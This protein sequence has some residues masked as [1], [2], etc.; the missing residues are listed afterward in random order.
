[1]DSEHQYLCWHR[2]VETSTRGFG[3]ER[4]KTRASLTASLQ[5]HNFLFYLVSECE[6]VL[7]SGSLFLP[8]D[9]NI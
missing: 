1:M 5:L 9:V 6:S 7:W 8:F 2:K 4:G 3:T